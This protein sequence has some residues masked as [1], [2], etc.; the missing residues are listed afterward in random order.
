MAQSKKTSNSNVKGYISN[1]HADSKYSGKSITEM[2]KGEIKDDE[3]QTPKGLGAPHPFNFEDVEKT[4]KKVGFVGGAC[5]KIRDRILGDFMIRSKSQKAQNKINEFL[6][7]S[8]LSVQAREWV[9]DAV[10]K[11]NGFMELDIENERVMVHNANNM[12]V[13]RKKN[14]KIKEY[15]QF[16]GKFKNFTRESRKFKSISP[17]RIA[18]LKINKIGGYPYGHGFVWGN[19]RVI[20]NTILNEQDLQKLISRKAGAPIHAKVGVPGESVNP[21]SIDKFDKDLTYMNN[22]TEWTTD[23]NVDMNVLD[24]GNIESPLVNVLDHNTEMFSFGMEIPLVL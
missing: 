15:N 8:M 23:A 1:K 16:T 11:G 10:V 14:G 21:T 17:D 6:R 12:Y 9:L 7:K 4:Y 3:I 20:E 22:K 19:E 18:H 5:N 24:F 13:K 2:M